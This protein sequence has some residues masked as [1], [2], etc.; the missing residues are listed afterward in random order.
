MFN[1]KLL[2]RV[3]LVTS[4]IAVIIFAYSQGK[5]SGQNEVRVKYAE[6]SN[7]AQL[8]FEMMLK[9]AA[10]DHNESIA[11]IEERYSKE[12]K[13]QSEQVAMFAVQIANANQEKIT[14]KE[15]V[16]H[17]QSD[18]SIIGVDAFSLYKQT[19]G[20]VKDPSNTDF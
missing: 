6:A 20:I 11:K 19:R 14:I 7:S 18:C 16:D 12:L 3:G 1:I 15:R 17:V 5:I 2:F 13:Y 10:E 8:Q 9:Q 4:L